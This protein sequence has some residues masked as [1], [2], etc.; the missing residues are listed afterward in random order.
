[1]PSRAD[2]SNEWDASKPFPAVHLLESW[3]PILPHFIRD[4][5]L[6]QLILPKVKAAVERWGSRRGE[7][8][9]SLANLVF[10]W[11]PLLG[12]RMEEVLEDA[13]R[14]IRHVLK[15]WVVKDGA[16]AELAKWRKEVSRGC[17]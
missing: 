6:D 7:G 9:T 1:M 3:S 16:P 13:K 2:V 4:N 12:E 11:L 8:S 15:N 14:R 10:P 5:I 17:S